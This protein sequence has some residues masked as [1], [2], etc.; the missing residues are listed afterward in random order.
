MH[1]KVLP[2]GHGL[3]PTNFGGVS[4]AEGAVDGEADGEGEAA[5]DDETEEP[6]DGVASGEP[7][8]PADAEAAGDEEVPVEAGAPA[9]EGVAEP[10]DDPAEA[11]AADP[12]GGAVVGVNVKPAGL[13]FVQATSARIRPASST[14]TGS[15]RSAPGAAER[16]RMVR[17]VATRLTP[18]RPSGRPGQPAHRDDPVA[19]NGQSRF[20]IA[21]AATPT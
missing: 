21:S 17:M 8:G 5:G 14:A 9:G 13:V 11:A 20:R 4:I 3:D 6:G 7:D 10:A 15:D 1:W 2:F 18:G 19:A 12:E 16:G